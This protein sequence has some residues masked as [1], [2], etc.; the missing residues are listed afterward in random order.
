M[1]NNT[2]LACSIREENAWRFPMS[3]GLLGFVL[4]MSCFGVA[5]KLLEYENSPSLP[6]KLVGIPMLG[7][8]IAGMVGGR[9]RKHWL[10]SLHTI[11]CLIAG[12]LS[13]HLVFL[14]LGRESDSR[15]IYKAKCQSNFKGSSYCH[16]Y[17]ATI[18][19]SALSVLATT[20]A[21]LGILS[22]VVTRRVPGYNENEVQEANNPTLESRRD[23]ES[24]PER[25]DE[26]NPPRQLQQDIDRAPTNHTR[27]DQPKQNQRHLNYYNYHGN[28]QLPASHHHR[29][30]FNIHHH[31]DPNRYI[32]QLYQQRNLP[33]IIAAHNCSLEQ[34]H[35][36]PAQR[37]QRGLSNT[38]DS[39]FA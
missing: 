39:S 22:H 8:G 28:S 19:M 17:A 5:M 26:R 10:V 24:A 38:T 30:A 16:R 25:T 1:C 14:F 12:V 34:S 9:M 11:F 31:R 29:Q 2:K 21:P 37:L 3:T 18:A 36:P 23:P 6:P 33:L 35:I 32:R 20:L 27:R 15:E 13:L 7:A 4:G